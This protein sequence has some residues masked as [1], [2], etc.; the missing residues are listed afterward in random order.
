MSRE[1]TLREPLF[2]ASLAAH[3]LTLPPTGLTTLQLNI[4]KLCNQAC[5]H[6]H[7]EASPKRTEQMDDRTLA[8][9]VRTIAREPRIQIV[10]ITG[11]APEL[12]PG[13]RNLVQGIRDLGRQVMVRHNL[14]VTLD[15][16]PRTGDSL[17]DLPRFF[18]RNRVALVSSLP[19]YQAF[20][21][22]KQRGSG[23]F[24]K[25]LES[26]RQL[27]AEG[28][29]LPGSDLSLD[30]VYN[31][32]GAFLPA[33]QEDL[34]R[35]FKRELKERHG[36]SFHRLF[37]ITN[38]PIHRFRQDLEKRGTLDAYMDKLEAAFNPKAAEGVMCRDLIS[39]D[40]EGRLHDCDFNQMLEFGVEKTAPQTIFD[41]DGDRLLERTIRFADHCF[42][43]TAGSGSSCGGATT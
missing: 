11:G 32:A 2:E 19:Y 16:H 15:P 28:Y 34:E 9:C 20:F 1:N 18:A 6:C 14:T 29:G 22:D 25:S 35:D 40:H 24:E 36:L 4:T 8:Q 33:A 42:G 17:E 39:V 38:M 10:D 37:A 3:G 31:P 43:C 41:F 23:V 26:M 7:V 27:N 30:L 21:T 13:F 5:Q 12:H